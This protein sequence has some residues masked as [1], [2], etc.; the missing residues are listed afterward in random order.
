LESFGAS[1]GSTDVISVMTL[2]EVH[3]TDAGEMAVEWYDAC[4]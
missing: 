4:T 1:V 3:G 2:A